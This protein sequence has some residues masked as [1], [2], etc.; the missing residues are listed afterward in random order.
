MSDGTESLPEAIES[1]REVLNRAGQADIDWGVNSDGWE[2]SITNKYDKPVVAGKI[3]PADNVDHIAR[4]EIHFSKTLVTGMVTGTDSI[5]RLEQMEIPPGG[6]VK[7]KGT[8]SAWLKGW[9]AA[10]VFWFKEPEGG[11]FESWCS[12]S[13]DISTSIL[14]LGTVTRSTSTGLGSPLEAVFPPQPRA[15]AQ[16]VYLTR[17]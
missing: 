7:V 10:C 5:D 2:F 1:M 3:T 13:I 17:G 14:E 6:T 15:C 9:P 12:I 4:T 11:T 8:K 16:H